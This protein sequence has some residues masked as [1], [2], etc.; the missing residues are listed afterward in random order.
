MDKVLKHSDANVASVA[1]VASVARRNEK[2][3]ACPTH[4]HSSGQCAHVFCRC[5]LHAQLTQHPN[6]EA[7]AGGWNCAD[8]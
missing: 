7:R 3:G 6:L 4:C 8:G 2:K 5:L 1:S